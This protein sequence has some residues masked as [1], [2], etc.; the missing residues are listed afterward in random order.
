MKSFVA[1][2]QVLLGALSLSSSRGKVVKHGYGYFRNREVDR[3]LVQ[4]GI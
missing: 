1:S 4:G 3:V 2:R